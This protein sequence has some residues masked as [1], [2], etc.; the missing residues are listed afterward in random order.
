MEDKIIK[1]QGI[2]LLMQALTGGYHCIGRRYILKYFDN[3]L[4]L[5]EQ[6]RNTTK[7][8]FLGEIDKNLLTTGD[9]L[10][11]DSEKR[12][13]KKA[14]R[15]HTP[16]DAWKSVGHTGTE[17]QFVSK[18]LFINLK[19]RLSCNEYVHYFRPFPR[20]KNF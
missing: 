4:V 1:G 11:T 7:E 5:G 14:G 3:H 2:T 8:Q 16:V 6:R 15:R 10:D 20:E 9:M 17:K 19:N 18:Q 12:R 13:R